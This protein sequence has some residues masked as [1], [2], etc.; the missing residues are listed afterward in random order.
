VPSGFV[1]VRV[2]SRFYMAGTAVHLKPKAAPPLS[3]AT[4]GHCRSAQRGIAEV[5]PGKN[6]DLASEAAVGSNLLLRALND[7]A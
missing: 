4:L 6:D 1:L 7:A 3:T 2:R 5:A